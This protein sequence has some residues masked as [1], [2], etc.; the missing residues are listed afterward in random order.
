MDCISWLLLGMDAEQ[1]VNLTQQCPISC[2]IECGSLQT[3]EVTKPFSISGVAS[4][5]APTAVEVLENESS[6]FFTKYVRL[7]QPKSWFTL[8]RVE[9][10]SQKDLAGRR[11]LRRS[12][13]EQGVNLG[14]MVLFS[15]FAINMDTGTIAQY[16]VK[17]IDDVSYT[18][19]LQ[20]SGDASLVD[21][22]VSS[23]MR[24]QATTAVAPERRKGNSGRP[25][26]IVSVVVAVLV[27][28]VVT[29]FLVRYQRRQGSG[30]ACT[31]ENH[32]VDEQSDVL[33][34]AA[35]MRSSL[36]HVLSLESVRQAG[37]PRSDNELSTVEASNSS[38]SSELSYK[39]SS[40]EGNDDEER[41][42]DPITEVFPMDLLDSLNGTP[43]T[44]DAIQ[45]PVQTRTSPNAA[46]ASPDFLTNLRN[47]VRSEERLQKASSSVE[48]KKLVDSIR[49]EKARPRKYQEYRE[50]STANMFSET[51]S[52]SRNVS[53]GGSSP[54]SSTNN[55]ST[56]VRQE[57]SSASSFVSYD[58][59]HSASGRPIQEQSFR[60]RVLQSTVFHSDPSERNSF[61]RGRCHDTADTGLRTGEQLHMVQIPCQQKLG[62]S[63]RC[64]P[65]VGV[66]I[67][68]VQEASPAFGLLVQGDRILSIDGT[69]TTRA[70][71]QEIADLLHR[72]PPQRRNQPNLLVFVVKRLRRKSSDSSNVTERISPRSSH[73]EQHS[74]TQ[75]KTALYRNEGTA[76]DDDRLLKLRR[77]ESP[78]HEELVVNHAYPN[79]K[80]NFISSSGSASR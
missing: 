10:L 53:A 78:L 69:T 5:L 50:E 57:S 9:L 4:F 38:K 66:S 42:R 27:G 62:L 74:Y 36:V 41:N 75:N 48:P 1:V 45:N 56:H 22:V 31:K 16:I 19:T 25:G 72:R 24:T 52:V 8:S 2:S 32:V 46:S 49:S 59:N 23:E 26:I 18:K 77:H 47:I 70:T 39:D 73:S 14:V 28:A 44:A 15:G 58:S 64:D 20:R 43:D 13:S 21:I 79:S 54:S 12:G 68:E 6:Q 33:S 65:I 11:N 67:E 80:C 71:L 7:L 63:I 34:P 35:S 30:R 29:A 37:S 55:G 51:R 60:K 61:C 17:G 3:F 76:R 40:Q